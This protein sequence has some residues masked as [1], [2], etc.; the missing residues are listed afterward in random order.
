MALDSGY[1]PRILCPTAVTVAS[2]ISERDR[3]APRA[4]RYLAVASPMPCP[5]PVMRMTLPSRGLVSA[6][7]NDFDDAEPMMD[8]FWLLGDPRCKAFKKSDTTVV[9]RGEIRV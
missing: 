5:A 3:I 6:I 1:W 8:V 2:E 7:V 9:R 4:A